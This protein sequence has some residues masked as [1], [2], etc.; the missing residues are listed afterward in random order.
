MSE[1]LNVIEADFTDPQQAEAVAALVNVLALETPPGDPL[2]DAVLKA[3]PAGLAAMPTSIVLLAR[4]ANQYAGVAVCFCGFSTFSA[5]PL[6]NIHDVAVHPEHRRQGVGRALMQAVESK[7]IELG[8]CKVTLEVDQDNQAA[9]QLYA[10]L[11]FVGQTNAEAP[12]AALF[13]HKRIASS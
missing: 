11:G 5:K 10:D 7:A 8:C 13:W 2:P 3:M 12:S 6:I 4:R 1:A 9:K